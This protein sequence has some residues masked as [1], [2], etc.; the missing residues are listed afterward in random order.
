M[1]SPDLEQRLLTNYRQQAA[2]YERALRLLDSEADRDA[3]IQDVVI[4]LQQIAE[5]DA[6]LAEDKTAW[7]Q[8]NRQAGTELRT[9]LDTLAVQI[10]TLSECVE[11]HMVQVAARKAQLAP[12]LDE[13][14]RQRTML[15]A[16]A[17]HRST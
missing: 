3:R 7:R 1:H 17:Q 15:K 8:T 2:H 4:I 5:M 6:A 10:R 12:A 14:M 11:Q 13:V 16:Y 9:L